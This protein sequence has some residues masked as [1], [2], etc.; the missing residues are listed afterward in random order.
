M[1]SEPY[2]I[3]YYSFGRIFH[4][5]ALNQHMQLSS[6]FDRFPIYLVKWPCPWAIWTVAVVCQFGPTLLLWPDRAILTLLEPMSLRCWNDRFYMS[7]IWAVAVAYPTWRRGVFPKPKQ[8]I[9][10]RAC[11]LQGSSSTWFKLW[12]ISNIWLYRLASKAFSV[13]IYGHLQVKT[14][15]ILD[16]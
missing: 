11:E 13:A 15:A 7:E 4:T 5:K 2:A 10:R 9:T 3:V 14:I 1:L 8:V 6:G 12:S 16:V